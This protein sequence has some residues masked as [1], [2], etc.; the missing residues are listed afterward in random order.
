[1]AKG[2]RRKGFLGVM[3]SPSGGFIVI[4][5]IF[6]VLLCVYPD[7]NLFTWIEARQEISRQEKQM[8]RYQ[9]QIRDMEERIDEL[10]QNRDTLEKFAR[11][12][13]HFSKQDE[14]IYLIDK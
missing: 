10:T 7:N 12:N 14:D 13:F 5:I 4:T 2:Q 8:R 1:M 11:E 6:A 3:T 9:Q